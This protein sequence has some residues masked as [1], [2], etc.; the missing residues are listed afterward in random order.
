MHFASA[1][2]IV[3]RMRQRIVSVSSIFRRRNGEGFHFVRPRTFGLGAVRIITSC[4]RT[5]L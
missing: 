4:D 1:V 2:N 3:L 5:R